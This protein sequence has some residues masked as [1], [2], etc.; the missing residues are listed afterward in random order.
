[1]TY[2]SKDSAQISTFEVK[3]SS[4]RAVAVE[5]TVNEVRHAH[6]HKPTELV[7]VDEID[8]QRLG[9]DYRL[10]G[11]KIHIWHDWRPDERYLSPTQYRYELPER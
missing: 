6:N 11:G 7:V 9:D 2:K 3:G 1:M 10:S 8:V 4:T 5:L